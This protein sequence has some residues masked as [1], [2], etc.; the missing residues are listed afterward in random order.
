MENLENYKEL[1]EK[2]T[3]L[4]AGWVGKDRLDASWI[5]VT[6]RGKN[7]RKKKAVGC[8]KDYYWGWI[9]FDTSTNSDSYGLY[10]EIY[11]LCEPYKDLIVRERQ[12]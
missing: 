3:A 11:K 12:L 4:S 8:E 2:L 6:M 9:F 7:W 1:K 10:E 5:C